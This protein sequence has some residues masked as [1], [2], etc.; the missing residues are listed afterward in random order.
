M[1]AID[2]FLYLKMYYFIHHHV[3]HSCD[4]PIVYVK[5]FGLDQDYNNNKHRHWSWGQGVTK[6]TGARVCYPLSDA[7]KTPKPIDF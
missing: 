1:T 3:V 2:F 4:L 6:N 7:K 5:T